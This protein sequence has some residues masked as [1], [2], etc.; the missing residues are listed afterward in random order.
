MPK[1]IAVI[2]DDVQLLELM[3]TVLGGAGYEVRTTAD[4]LEAPRLVK[5][6]KPDLVL[7][8]IWMPERGGWEVLELMKLDPALRRI[9]I[10]LL[11]AAE[12][13]VKATEPLVR[14]WK[15]EALFKPFEIPDLLAKIERLIGKP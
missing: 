15:V 11:T 8:D 5:E 14:G 12:E 7:L 4:S 3:E 6:W 10:I 13:E 1:R 9:P 2:D